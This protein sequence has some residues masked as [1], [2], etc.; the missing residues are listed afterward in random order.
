MYHNYSEK[1]NILFVH[2]PKNAGNALISQLDIEKSEHYPLSVLQKMMPKEIFDNAKKVAVLRN[3]W[4][5]MSSYYNFRQHKGHDP[6]GLK[7]TN[8][9]RS[10]MMSINMTPYDSLSQYHWCLAENKFRIWE[11][12]DYIL[13][14][15]NLNQD[16]WTFCNEE[17][18]PYQELPVVNKVN[19]YDWRSNY[20][21]QDDISLVRNYF[22]ADITS[23]DYKFDKPNDINLMGKENIKDSVGK[24]TINRWLV[25]DV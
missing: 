3:P 15:E 17:N 4:E 5:R 8:W 13:N 1:Y 9:I 10:G 23:F 12:M 16:W 24:F 18:I 20:I 14:Y 21:L 11:S 19:Q 25:G 2:I 22:R 7:F 6:K